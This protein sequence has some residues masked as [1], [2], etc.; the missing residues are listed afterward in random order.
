MHAMQVID[1]LSSGVRLVW[2]PV[3]QLRVM[4]VR[5]HRPTHTLTRSSLI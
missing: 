4:K 5:P 1:I 3:Q 2:S